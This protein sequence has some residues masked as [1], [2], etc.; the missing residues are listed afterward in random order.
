MA[1]S[2]SLYAINRDEVPLS[3]V[4]KESD[5]VSLISASHMVEKMK[6]AKNAVFNEKFRRQNKDFCGFIP[7]SPLPVPITDTSTPH[8]LDYLQMHKRL[9]EDGRP[10]FCGL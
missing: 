3:N 9:V 2:S 1:G 5:T 7:L 4:M 8:D 10:N 6:K